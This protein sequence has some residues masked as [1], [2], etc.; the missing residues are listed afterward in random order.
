MENTAYL[1]L[2]ATAAIVFGQIFVDFIETTNIFR[3]AESVNF[4]PRDVVSAVLPTA[5]WLAGW[6]TDWL[7]GCLS[8]AGIVSKRL[9]LS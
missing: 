6:L 9:N 3:I 8:H 7:V 1:A 4:Y 2:Y 5:T